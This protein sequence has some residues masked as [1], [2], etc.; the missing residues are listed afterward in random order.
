MLDDNEILQAVERL[1]DEWPDLVGGDAGDLARWLGETAYDDP[2]SL[3]H[4]ANRVL[5]L[6][7][8]H[9]QARARVFGEL[10]ITV[11]RRS[12]GVYFQPP[13]DPAL[14][15]PGALVVCPVDP[16]HYKVR[17]RQAGQRCPEHSAL[18]VAAQE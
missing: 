11:D 13:G 17:L 10:G 15:A 5:D 12:G 14:V 2:E 18:L 6:L 9:P 8:R 1:R 3:R 7:E 4:T 16:G